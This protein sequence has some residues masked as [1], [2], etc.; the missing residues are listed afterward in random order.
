VVDGRHRR[1]AETA[2]IFPQ[3]RQGVQRKRV[4]RRAIQ[5]EHQIGYVHGMRD[6]RVPQ[7]KDKKV[8]IKTPWQGINDLI[9]NG[10][11]PHRF[12]LFGSEDRK[13][14]GHAVDALATDAAADGKRVLLYSLDVEGAYRPSN[15]HVVEDEFATSKAVLKAL[16]KHRG[17]LDLVVVESFDLIKRGPQLARQISMRNALRDIHR[18]VCGVGNAVLALSSVTKTHHECPGCFP[19]VD[20]AFMASYIFA[21]A[22]RTIQ[23]DKNESGD[24]SPILAM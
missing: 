20:M 24:L 7:R 2:S 12:C 22:G 14:A 5:P 9:P 18:E 15:A 16:R 4:A 11:P 10:I 19:M 23:L 6:A 3:A 21:V 1:A 8:N 17:Q 13:H